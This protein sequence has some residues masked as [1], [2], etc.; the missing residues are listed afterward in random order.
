MDKEI[1]KCRNK[2][3]SKGVLRNVQRNVYILRYVNIHIVFSNTKKYIGI[4]INECLYTWVF[5]CA[6]YLMYKHIYLCV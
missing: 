1:F 2:C 6:H 3:V 4:N 5:N